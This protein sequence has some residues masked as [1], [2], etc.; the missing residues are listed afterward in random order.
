MDRHKYRVWNKHEQCSDHKH[1]DRAMIDCETG[2]P[3][4]YNAL[5]GCTL[6]LD[7]VIV[8]QCTGLKDRSG[9]LIYV[10]DIWQ[11]RGWE[12][13]AGRQA[14]PLR[15][16]VIREDTFIQDLHQ[17]FCI[18][19]QQPVVIIGNIHKDPSLLETE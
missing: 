11:W 6:D 18:H 17:L 15:T 16:A 9:K 3:V 12:V 1:P 13:E 5:A 14:R 19:S 2:E 8:E 4:Y 7:D 10:G